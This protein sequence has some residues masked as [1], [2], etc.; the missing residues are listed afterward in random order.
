MHVVFTPCYT[1]PATELLETTSVRP[2][3]PPFPV[4]FSFC[5]VPSH[6]LLVVIATT[7][8][9]PTTTEK[10][11]IL[12]TLLTTPPPQHS[13]FLSTSPSLES[14]YTIAAESGDTPTPEQGEEVNWHYTAFVPDLKGKRV[15]ELDGDRW[16]PLVHGDLAD[17]AGAGFGVKARRV[18]KE[19]YF[20]SEG[21][22]G[23]FSVLALVKEASES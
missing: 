23:M 15:V 2:V 11:S 1:R 20:E 19:T 14:L 12:Y 7:T 16:G 21:I 4:T 8:D 13:S 22:E 5:F 3:H 17:E 6:H 9:T 18:I 10:D